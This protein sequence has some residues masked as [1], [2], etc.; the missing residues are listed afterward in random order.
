[1]QNFHACCEENDVPIV[2]RSICRTAEEIETFLKDWALESHFTW[3]VTK[4]AKDMSAGRKNV[5]WKMYHCQSSN[6][7]I[8]KETETPSKKHTNCSAKMTI[9]IKKISK[10]CE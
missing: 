1:V 7:K 10:R 2:I 3:R 9:T 8:A 4:T 5:F 6:L